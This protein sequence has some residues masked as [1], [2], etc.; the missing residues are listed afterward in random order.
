[1]AD[2]LKLNLGCGKKILPG[3]VNVDFPN[4]WSGKKPDLECDIRVLPYGNDTVDEVMAIHVIEHFYLWEVPEILKEWA[5]VLKPGGQLILECPSLNKVLYFLTLQPLVLSHTMFALY[6]DPQYGDPDMMHKW[7]YSKEHL[8]ALM[9][10][11]FAD[12][13]VE[14][15]QYHKPERDMRI[16]GTKQWLPTAL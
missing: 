12:V 9:A 2:R 4:N 13:K 6:G 15:A 3:Y 11:E 1:M 16:V 7:C 10:R 14:P 8:S 5:R